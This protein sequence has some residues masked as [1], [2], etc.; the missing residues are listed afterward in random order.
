[1]ICGPSTVFQATR[2]M[3]PASSRLRHSSADSGPKVDCCSVI[4]IPSPT[5]A[6]LP[7][8]L[9]HLRHV[10]E[11]LHYIGLV[12]RQLCLAPRL[13]LSGADRGPL[14]VVDRVHHQVE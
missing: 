4:V 8:P 5:S 6:A 1:M 9:A 12:A 2:P 10:L 14:G 11:M 7:G 13:E 3:V